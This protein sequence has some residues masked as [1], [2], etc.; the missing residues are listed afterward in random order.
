MPEIARFYGLIIKMFF[1]NKEYDPPHIHV[2][3]GEY[4]GL[5]DLYN[6]E[7]KTLPDYNLQ[8]QFQTGEKKIYDVKPLFNKYEELDANGLTDK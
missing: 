5:I 1:R 4:T 7:V 2:I 8:V 3:Y 6:K